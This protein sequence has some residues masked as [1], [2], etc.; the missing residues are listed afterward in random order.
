LVAWL[1]R[2]GNGVEH[3]SPPVTL[4]VYYTLSSIE[5]SRSLHGSSDRRRWGDSSGGDSMGGGIDDRSED[6]E[7]EEDSVAPSESDG[8][9][10]CDWDDWLEPILVCAQQ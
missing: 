4:A 5:T 2:V 10:D 6:D 8:S 1:A 3:G 7:E 9:P